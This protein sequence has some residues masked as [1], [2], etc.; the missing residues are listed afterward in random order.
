VPVSPEKKGGANFKE[1]QNYFGDRITT[2]VTGIGVQGTMHTNAC[3]DDVND[4]KC[5]N[6]S[7]K[8]SVDRANSAGVCQREDVTDAT[9]ENEHSEQQ[10][11]LEEEKGAQKANQSVFAT[12][13][14]R[15]L[16][17]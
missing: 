6:Y 16:S 1:Q 11:N 4:R 17:R 14:D 8:E 5:Q 7:A 10:E 13:I 2:Q 9:N 3:H 12:E 15:G